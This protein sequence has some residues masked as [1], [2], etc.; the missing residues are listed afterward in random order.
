MKHGDSDV[1]SHRWILKSRFLST[2]MRIF[3][4]VT[5]FMLVLWKKAEF[6]LF[7]SVVHVGLLHEYQ[8]WNW[9]DC[10]FISRSAQRSYTFIRFYSRHVPRTLSYTLSRTNTAINVDRAS[11][12]WTCCFVLFKHHVIKQGQNVYN[13]KILR[14]HCWL[15]KL[16]NNWDDI[17]VTVERCIT[18][19]L[20]EFVS[21]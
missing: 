5:N 21:Q 16:Y 6:W 4:S 8:S 12:R 17:T 20:R 13:D 14:R 3:H 1:I 18:S 2:T 7:E 15:A 11:S 9:W 10:A 19:I